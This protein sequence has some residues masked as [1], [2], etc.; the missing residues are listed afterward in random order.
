MTLAIWR[1]ELD[2]KVRLARGQVDRGPEEM[3]ADGLTVRDFMVD[4]GELLRCRRL[5]PSAG[6]VPRGASLLAPVDEQQVWAAGVTFPRSRDARR[7]EAADGGDVY[8]RVYDAERP[9]LFFKAAPGSVCGS[10]EP[11]GIRADSAWNVPEP[12]LALFLGPAGDIRG[13]TLGNDMS[14]RSIE[15][16]NPLYLPQAKV[17]D[18]SC[19]LGPALVPLEEVPGW[20]NLTLA[21]HVQRGVDTIYAETVELATIR[22]SPE[23]LVRWLFEAN[24]FGDGVVLLTGTS[25]VPP[26][27]FSILEGDTVTITSPGLGALVQPVTRVGRSAPL[28]A[29][30]LPRSDEPPARSPYERSEA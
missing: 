23:E 8:Q 1:I 13:L 9:E 28:P 7:E 3:L 24:T 5:L 17:Y 25:I 11:V 29:N 20:Q 2:G 16:E 19:G 18:R 10:G 30:P 27:D 4:D 21:L 12:E 6:A 14:S 26:S 15:G 22:R